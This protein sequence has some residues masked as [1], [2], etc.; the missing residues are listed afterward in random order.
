MLKL[1]TGEKRAAQLCREHQ[2]SETSPSRWRQQF[3]DSGAKVFGSD[4]GAWTAQQ[5]LLLLTLAFPAGTL[6]DVD[7]FLAASSPLILPFVVICPR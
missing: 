3:L 6:A 5:R 2:V 4:V 1:L 7:H